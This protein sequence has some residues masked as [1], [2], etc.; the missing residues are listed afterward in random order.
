[1]KTKSLR[2]EFFLMIEQSYL[3]INTLNGEI[4]LLQRT[5]DII[6]KMDGPAW[7]KNARHGM[8]KPVAKKTD[9][10]LFSNWIMPDQPQGYIRPKE[11]DFL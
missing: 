5:P 3:M 2:H 9:T 6:K 1:M 10:D 8:R 7:R 11:N 4:K